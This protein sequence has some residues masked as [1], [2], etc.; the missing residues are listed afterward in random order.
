MSHI[1]ISTFVRNGKRYRRNDPFSSGD[2]DLIKA[3]EN[4]KLIAKDTPKKLY[5]EAV[6]I[7]SG[8]SLTIEDCET[9]RKWKA[10]S[11][12]R[13]V[14]VTNSSYRIAPFA[15]I[16]YACDR[17][18]LVQHGEAIKKNF[19]G[20]VL[21]HSAFTDAN[22]ARCVDYRNS[23]ATSIALAAWHGCERIYLLGFDCSV[24]NGFHWH[25]KHEG[26]LSNCKSLAEWPDIFKRVS[27]DL[28][29]K[30]VINLTRQTELTCFERGEVEKWLTV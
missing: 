23:G 17:R 29:N 3:Y 18:Y 4:K 24:K 22:K 26:K 7:A 6:C 28:R 12:G 14:I 11:S 25:G 2:I 21:T 5:S 20:D 27:V 30:Q 15:D 13:L 9:V 8:P 19:Q 10:K 16:L 1:V